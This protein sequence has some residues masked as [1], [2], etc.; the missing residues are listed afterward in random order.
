MRISDYLSSG[1]CIMELKAR[2]KRGVIEEIASSLT[3]SPNLKEKDKFVDDIL[4]R[5]ALGSTGIGQGVAIPHSRT[6][7]VNGFVVA[8]G[9]SKE[10]V[11]FDSLDGSKAKL[12]FLMG[13]NP[14]CLSLYLRLLAQLSKLLMDSTFRQELIGAKTADEVIEIFNR[15]ET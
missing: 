3:A 7:A 9:R 15:F 6:E 11:E 1:F 2:D 13:A 12:I 4:K 5:E 10:G 14:D 8:F